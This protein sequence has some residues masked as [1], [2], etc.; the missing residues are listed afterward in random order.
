M[1][2]L[3]PDRHPNRD[4]FVADILDVVPKDDLG[5]MEHPLFSL[6]K[7]PDTATRLYEHN[8]NSIK[9]TPSADGLATIWDKDVLIYCISQLIEGINRGREPNRTLQIRAHDLLIA[10]NRHTGGSDYDRLHKAFE[11]LRGTTI[12]TDIKTNGERIRSGFGMIDEWN[13]IEKSPNDERMIAVTVTLSRWLYQ[14]VL[15][16]EVLSIDRDYFRL[17]GGLERRLYEIARKHCGNQARWSIRLELLHKK[18]GALSPLRPF[19]HEVRKIITS[20]H[21]PG[22]RLTFDDEKNQIY[23]YNRDGSKAAKAKF[24][25][26][27]KQL[28]NPRRA[29]TKGA[30]QSTTTKPQIDLF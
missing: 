4:F 8:G 14:A 23:F 26:D 19:K 24:D 25:D 10:T 6:S 13:I 5:S 12:T 7:R 18:T 29:Q 28:F 9:I 20:N 1:K 15:G 11:R 21:L 27:I 16:K 22:Y 2:K 3:I 17:R 30:K